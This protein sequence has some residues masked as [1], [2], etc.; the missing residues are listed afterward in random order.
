VFHSC[1]RTRTSSLEVQGSSCSSLERRSRLERFR[2]L[3]QFT[4][5]GEMQ[6]RSC[7]NAYSKERGQW[8][9]MLHDWW[10][11]AKVLAST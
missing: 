10:C 1:D 8:H 4:C 3:H 11:S 5:L 6:R 2:E 9:I 7:H